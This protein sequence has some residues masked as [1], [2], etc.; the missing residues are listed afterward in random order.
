MVRKFFVPFLVSAGFIAFT[1]WLSGFVGYAEI[2]GLVDFPSFLVSI[3]VPYALAS[4]VFGLAGTRAAY[5]APFDSDAGRVE[6]AKARAY[7]RNLTRYIVAWAVF[8][9]VTGFIALLV[10]SA[11]DG[12][13]MG[14]N[15]AVCILSALYAAVIPLLLVIPFQATIDDRLAETD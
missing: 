2:G 10:A 15:V 14:R 7:F 13:A 4:I 12:A 3:V 11:G 9:I 1:L 5:R 6:L 8:A